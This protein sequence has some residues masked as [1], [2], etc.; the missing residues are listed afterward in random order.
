MV[1]EKVDLGKVILEMILDYMPL[2]IENRR[3]IE[4]DCA[5]EPIMVRG[6]RRAIESIV[7]NLI[8]NALRAEPDDGVA[9][10]R[11]DADATVEVIDH[12]EGVAWEDRENIFEP[13]W[14]K[15][16]AKTSGTGLGLSI[17]KD[18]MKHLDGSVW[19]EETP[20]GGATFKL[21]FQK[22]RAD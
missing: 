8:D 15:S 7:A 1:D 12:G 17:V 18:M 22:A 5:S 10:L 21:S 16:E 3:L 2:A 9:L 13:F 4:L 19:V 11:V 20:G 6:N 14:R